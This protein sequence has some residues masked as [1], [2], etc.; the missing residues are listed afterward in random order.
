ML[1]LYKADIIIMSLNITCSHYDMAEKLLTNQSLALFI[2][3]RFYN[4]YF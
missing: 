1:V 4:F 2:D 3:D